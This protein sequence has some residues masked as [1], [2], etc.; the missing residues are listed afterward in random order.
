MDRKLTTSASSSESWWICGGAGA[1]S[2][3]LGLRGRGGA[4]ARGRR[5]RAAAASRRAAARRRPEPAGPARPPARP[6]AAPRAHREGV[7]GVVVLLPHRPLA[8]QA[9]ARQRLAVHAAPGGHARPLAA[10][11][12]RVLS[13]AHGARARL[14]APGHRLRLGAG[15]RCQAGRRHC[16]GQQLRA[17]H[18]LLRAAC[19]WVRKRRR[20]WAACRAFGWKTAHTSR[21]CTLK[22]GS[23]RGST[24][25]GRGAPLER[26]R[27]GGRPGGGGSG[28]RREVTPQ[29][30]SERWAWSAGGRI[31]PFTTLVWT[32]ADPHKRARA[33]K[34]P[35]PP[36]AACGPSA[37]P[38]APAGACS[39]RLARAAQTRTNAP[40]PARGPCHP[41]AACGP[42]RNLRRSRTC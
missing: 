15:G 23:C 5:R 11:R 35:L 12:A 7:G 10:Q 39:L 29:P 4:R 40:A 8:Q 33:G 17:A 41:G 32:S 9:R 19:G 36:P 28:R 18:G 2:A 6:R 21:G 26:Q 34:R 37:G 24:S 42:R 22:K 13:H 14:G 31:Q 3:R 25:A 1:G 27:P 30:H 38:G 20:R 16:D